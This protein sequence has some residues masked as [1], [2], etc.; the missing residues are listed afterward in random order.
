MV[1][2]LPC[3][4]VIKHLLP[5]LRV[6]IARELVQNHGVSQVEAARI[7]GITQPA[8]YNYLRS[9]TKPSPELN[10]SVEEV[11]AVARELVNAV[12]QGDL[13]QQEALKRFCHLCLRLRTNGPICRIHEATVPELARESCSLCLQDLVGERRMS[14]EEYELLENVR[15]AVRLIEGS[16]SFPELVPE[17]GT[18]VAMARAGATSLS[19]VVGVQ[20]RIHVAAGRARATGSPA[21]GGSSHIASAVLTAMKYDPSTRAAVNIRYDPAV[22]QICEEMGL[23]ISHFSRREEPPEVKHVDGRTIPW[24]IEC[25]ITRVGSIPDVVYDLGDIGKEAMVF[26]FRP[27]AF[28]AA[29]LANRIAEEYRRRKQRNKK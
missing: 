23:L 27:T 16:P 15:L 17:I 18:N 11:Q 20:G 7:L 5:L 10:R 2:R 26:I 19:D 12:C 4:L 1:L 9:N 21:F 6:S 8:V 14:L 13:H 28:D 29:Y 24:G 25:A 22:I 3:E